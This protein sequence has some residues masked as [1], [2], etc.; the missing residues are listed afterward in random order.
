MSM[1]SVTYNPLYVRVG[2][3]ALAVVLVAA[4]LVYLVHRSRTKRVRMSARAPGATP[5]PRLFERYA[6]PDS[7]LLWD[8]MRGALILLSICV[9]AG[10]VLI[11]IPDGTF[12]RMAQRLRLRNAEPPPQERISLLYLGD[13]IKGKEFRIRGVIRNISTQPIEKLDA[14]V[15]IYAPDGSLLETTV[16][17]MDAESIAPD[18][19][20]SFNLTFPDNNGQFRSYSVD[21]KLRQGE[22][23]P[24]KDMRAMRTGG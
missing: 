10:F 9:A 8:V 20:S 17:R 6:R 4:Y 2:I 3:F 14:T 23:M 21:F 22:A 7:S 15:R 11:L 16:V 12:D 18:A 1:L 24:Y 5:D 19:T 13:E